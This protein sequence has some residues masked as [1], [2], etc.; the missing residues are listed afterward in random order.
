MS[1][2]DVHREPTKREL[3]LFALLLVVFGGVV[4][5]LALAR[6]G[7]LGIAA[8]VAAA[9]WVASF[10][11]NSEQSR[12]TQLLGLVPPLVFGAAYGAI[13]GGMPEIVVAALFWAAGVAG[14]TAVVADPKFGRRFYSAWLLSFLPV[15]WT[16]SQL[17]LAVVYYLVVTP[18]GVVMQL[19]GRDPLQRTF[20]RSAK[21]YWIQRKPPEDSSRYFKQF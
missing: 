5:G 7:V 15:S 10:L 2:I 19:A 8:A 20:D 16:V 11:W 9:L 14:A 18:M 6:P 17:L 12:R 21:T 1:F 4:G 13:R 3:L